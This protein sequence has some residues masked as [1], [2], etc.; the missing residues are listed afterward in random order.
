MKFSKKLVA[1]IAVMMM[2]CMM[3]TACGT[4]PTVNNVVK[5]EDGQ[6]DGVIG[7]TFRTV[8]FDYSVDSV[9]YPTEYEGYTPTDGMQ[10]L[11][12]RKSVV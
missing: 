9:A 10:L 11:E 8:F 6:A 4:S 2:A 1:C 12:D 5:A 7:T 3:L